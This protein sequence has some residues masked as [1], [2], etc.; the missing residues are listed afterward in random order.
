M[1]GT[2]HL[3]ET[4][5]DLIVLLGNISMM[6]SK[7]EHVVNVLDFLERLVEKSEEE[8]IDT[9]FEQFEDELG[10]MY[11]QHL[12]LVDVVKAVAEGIVKRGGSRGEDDPIVQGGRK[13]YLMTN[14]EEQ[15]T[16]S[17]KPQGN[18]PW[19]GGLWLSEQSWIELCNVLDCHG[20]ASFQTLLDSA[21]NH[22]KR[23]DEAMARVRSMEM[24][25]DAQSKNIE[26]TGSSNTECTC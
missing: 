13:G 8:D 6:R 20:N 12:T 3:K 14:S 4:R 2:E 21:K 24:E 11:R 10:E 15:P 25:K 9:W 16:V 22:R 18:E 7:T 23:H 1:R 5:K 26:D 19:S 17:P